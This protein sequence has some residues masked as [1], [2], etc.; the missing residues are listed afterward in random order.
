M[1]ERKVTDESLDG[2][3]RF[4]AEA[5]KAKVDMQVILLLL[6]PL[7]AA[8]GLCDAGDRA[9]ARIHKP[10]APPAPAPEADEAAAKAAR[11]AAKRAAK[12]A[13]KAAAAEP[14]LV[15]VTGPEWEGP[16]MLPKAAQLGRD[17][18]SVSLDACKWCRG[19][20]L[21]GPG[22]ARRHPDCFRAKH[23]ASKPAKPAKADGDAAALAAKALAEAAAAEAAAAE[24]ERKAAKA[25]RK[26]AKAAAKAAAATA[27]GG[28][29]ICG[30]ALTGKQT[31]YDSNACRR[32]ANRRR[33]V[34]V[35][36]QP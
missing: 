33:M 5:I 3:G 14:G 35:R 15:L 17:H 4:L 31:K 19:P 27:P 36:A 29:L 13:R 23:R 21:R 28:C 7:L 8:L 32:E 18:E 9:R 12:A 1:S 6:V 22:D 2:L 26:A 30:K 11:K 34:E 25:E 20:I 10:K 24:A 16:E